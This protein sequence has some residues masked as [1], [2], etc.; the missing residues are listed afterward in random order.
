MD[1]T[2]PPPWRD[3][4]LERYSEGGEEKREQVDAAWP[5]LHVDGQDLRSHLE[6]VGL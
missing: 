4:E 3:L 1:S 2:K 5:S 6:L